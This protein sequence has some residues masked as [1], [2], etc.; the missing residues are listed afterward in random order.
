MEYIEDI[1][2]AHRAGRRA[3]VI[4]VARTSGSAPREAGARMLVFD[5]AST[6]GTVGG[7]AIELQAVEMAR[8]L[9][10]SG[11]ARPR[12][13]TMGL[14]ELGMSC[15]GQMTLFFEPLLQSQTLYI[16][17]AGHVATALAPA[18]AA[19]GFRV[20]VF[21]PR[22]DFAVPERFP[23][24]TDVFQV[25]FADAPGKVAFGPHAYLVVMTP[26]HDH[27]L[28]VARACIERPWAYLGVISSKAK[29]AKFRKAFEEEGLAAEL[30]A[31]VRMPVGLPIGGRTPA[32]I[33]VSIT[34]ELIQVYREGGS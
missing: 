1:A 17:G 8:G 14:G 7:G 5:D 15:G 11:E 33:A 24:A 13:E 26:K 10:D 18:A 27:D 20:V 32:E 16:F 3:V 23:A 4:T 9:L 19:V 25:D 30:V 22:T 28:E 12:L 2:R 21:D 6:L 31:R 29:A 34:A